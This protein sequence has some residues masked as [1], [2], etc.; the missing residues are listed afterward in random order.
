MKNNADILAKE[1]DAKNLKKI[2][3]AFAKKKIDAAAKEYLDLLYS[4][5]MGCFRYIFYFLGLTL[6]APKSPI[7]PYD[8][9]ENSMLQNPLQISELGPNGT[10]IVHHR[11]DNDPV[12]NQFFSFDGGTDI[13]LFVSSIVSTIIAAQKNVNRAIEKIVGKYY[14]DYLTDVLAVVARVLTKYR[15]SASVQAIHDK[16][17]ESFRAHFVSCAACEVLKIIGNLFPDISVDLVRE[18]DKV[19]PPFAR[20]NDVYR[21]KLL[22]DTVPQI[23]A[24]IDHV[25][26]MMPDSILSVRNRFYDLNNGR[27]YRDAK[28][29]VGFD[30][31]GKIFPLEIIC[32]VRTFFDS[33]RQ[34][35]A[36][37]ESIRA[38]KNMNPKREIAELHHSGI[39][40]YNKIICQTVSFLLHR[41]GWNIMY[42]KDLLIDSFFRGFPEIA[43]LPYSQKIVDT[44]LGKI[45]NSVRNEVF[46]LPYAPRTLSQQE[47][48]SVFRYITEY[49]LFSAL[50][51]SY[52]FEE[53][54]NM[55]FSGKLFNFVMKELYRYYEND[56]L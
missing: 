4:N 24:F 19:A 2:A 49:V 18:L 26:E 35:H 45:D 7:Y 11:F 29:I 15:K 34:S 41:V 28:I 22:F 17:T 23:N 14:D 55:G 40:S 25:R 12:R 27:D 3:D 42:E 9:I 10:Y 56:V 47:E 20:L 51:Y 33:E 16:I 54:K 38:I 43:G 13:R 31:R 1:N 37:Y 39:V 44:I 50:P 52:K 6:G 36:G 46:H 30:F 53:I 32:N 21:M 5:S 48:I 8:S